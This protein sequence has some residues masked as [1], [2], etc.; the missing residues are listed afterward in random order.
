MMLHHHPLA[1]SRH[2]ADR[3]VEVAT[4]IVLAAMLLVAIPLMARVPAA[5]DLEPHPRPAPRPLAVVDFP[6]HARVDGACVVILTKSA[7]VD[8]GRAPRAA[9]ITSALLEDA[10][11]D[12]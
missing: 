7:A 4:V 11:F 10:C 6:E 9:E 12:A 5:T 2:T 8:N 1:M 3:L